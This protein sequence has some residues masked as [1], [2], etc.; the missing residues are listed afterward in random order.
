MDH[1]I[2]KAD[3]A[4]KRHGVKGAP[5]SVSS[6]KEDNSMKV[7]IVKMQKVL[8]RLHPTKEGLSSPMAIDGWIVATDGHGM[9]A[10]SSSEIGSMAQDKVTSFVR[11]LIATELSEVRVPMSELRAIATIPDDREPCDKCKS[12]GTITCLACESSGEVDCECDCWHPHS[13]PCDKCDG[14]G[15]LRCGCGHS[16][17]LRTV[18]TV[19]IDGVPFYPALIG[20]FLYAVTADDF[21]FTK[22]NPET[23]WVIGDDGWRLAV[24]PLRMAT[25]EEHWPRLE[26]AGRLPAKDVHHGE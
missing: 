26:L 21:R 8:D 19:F 23:G 20:E 9:L 3:E 10:V 14:R 15:G 4:L 2:K 13:R 6:R 7:D 1:F 16:P 5:A 11:K 18:D 24:M 12:S 25:G 22:S 17:V